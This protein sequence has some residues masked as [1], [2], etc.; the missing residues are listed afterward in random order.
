M[1]PVRERRNLR[2]L[3]L[4]AEVFL[5]AFDGAVQDFIIFAEAESGEVL[6]PAD[7]E[8]STDRQRRDFRFYREVTAEVLVCSVEAE[9]PDIRGNEVRPLG[10]QHAK[11]NLGE[12]ARET[13]AL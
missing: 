8:K 11:S 10:G 12:P 3:C 5:Q 6:R 7:A 13:V 1:R 4:R 9:R 2:F